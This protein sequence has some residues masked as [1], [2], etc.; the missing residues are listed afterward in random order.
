MQKTGVLITVK[1]KDNFGYSQVHQKEIIKDEEYTMDES[2]FGE[3]LFERPSP[4][5]IAPWERESVEAAPAEGKKKR[6]GK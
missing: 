1:A 2:E 4:E 3:A 5:W 6:E